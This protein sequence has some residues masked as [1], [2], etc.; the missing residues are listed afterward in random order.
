[1]SSRFAPVLTWQDL[2]STTTP[3]DKANI[4]RHE[5]AIGAAYAGEGCVDLDEPQFTSGGTTDDQRLTA[6]L[7]HCA[8]QTMRPWIR[9]PARRTAFSQG[10]RVPFNGM[11]LVG[12][13][14]PHNKNLEVEF[15]TNG[16]P[17]VNHMVRLTC[18]SGASSWFVGP[19][20]DRFDVIVKD[21][22]IY[23]NS[24]TQFWQQTA[25]TLYST[26]FD[27]LTFFGL[28][29]GIGSQT[30]KALLTQTMFCGHWSSIGIAG[31]QFNLGGSDN[32]L[33]MYGYINIGSPGGA[34][35]ANNRP[36]M[37]IDSM[38]KTSIGYLYVTVEPDDDYGGV[39]LSGSSSSGGNTIF[40][41]SFEGLNL[42]N[43]AMRAPLR[44]TG[45]NWNFVGGWFGQTSSTSNALGAVEQTGGNIT[46]YGPHYMRSDATAVAFP[47]LYQTGGTARI[48]DLTSMRGGEQARVRWSDGTTVL[49]PLPAN[50]LA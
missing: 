7:S 16:S 21:L 22:A 37:I 29:A 11:K 42:A 18:G 10:G 15:N 34:L 46:M 23:G 13:N 39:L 43:P 3:W 6:A 5:K 28:M 48:R 44:I 9:F 2:P 49:A 26:T 12:P 41:G 33:W 45:G 27:S 20:A 8:A 32:A 4:E 31:T 40:G 24:N 38:S 17:P 36:Q 1:M 14:S 30:S 19:A 50:D 35:A 25:G 47:F